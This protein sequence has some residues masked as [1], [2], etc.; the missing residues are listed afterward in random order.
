[1]VRQVGKARVAGHAH[2]RPAC[3]SVGIPRPLHASL[4]RQHVQARQPLR[5]VGQDLDVSDA[6]VQMIGLVGRACERCARRDRDGARTAPP[7]NTCSVS[8][9]TWGNAR[10]ASSKS[11]DALSVASRLIGFCKVLHGHPL[12]RLGLW[13]PYRHS[14]EIQPIRRFCRW[15]RFPLR[16]ASPTSKPCRCS[17]TGLRPPARSPLLQWRQRGQLIRRQCANRAVDDPRALARSFSGA[18]VCSRS[19]SVTARS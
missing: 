11:L 4:G 12:A 7:L 8:K 6:D 19:R 15:K 18:S 17:S 14:A 10:M 5:V 13:S 2:G 9:S 3:V 1:M 16:S